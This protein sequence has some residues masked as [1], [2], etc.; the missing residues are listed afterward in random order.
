MS[1]SQPTPRL[2]W[3]QVWGLTAKNMGRRSLCIRDQVGAVIV[4]SSNRIIATGY[5]GPPQGFP[6]GELTCDRWCPRARN[7]V[8]MGLPAKPVELA[9]DYSDCP[10]LH[11]E[12]NALSVCDQKDRIDGTIYVTSGICIGCGKLI[13]NSGLTRAVVRASVQ[14]AHRNSDA[15]YQLLRDCGME[16]ELF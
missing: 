2:S 6:H 16:V 1:I 5:N 15:T 14:P 13:A 8:K 12:A 11:A 4:D 7:G 3:D 9:A 10:A